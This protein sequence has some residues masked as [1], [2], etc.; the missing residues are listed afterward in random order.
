[1]GVDLGSVLKREEISLDH[2]TS[3][4]VAIDA[5]NTLYQFLSIIRQRDGTPL[6][7][8]EGRITSHLSGIIYRMSNLLERGVKP[9]FVFDGAPPMLKRK[10]LDKRKATREEALKKYGEAK[11]RGEEAFKYAQASARINSDIVEDSEELLG[12][13]GIP[14]VYAPSEG[15]AQAAFMVSKGDADFVASQDYDSMLFGA[16][17]LVR[18]LTISG[19]RKLPRKNVY[20]NVMPEEIRLEEVLEEL[21]IDRE[22]L[23]GVGILTGT[24]YNGGI[25][26]IGPKK[27]LKLI[28]KHGTIEK[29]LT[30]INERIEELDEVK[31]IFLNPNVTGDYEIRWGK[32]NEE[33]VIEFLCEEHGFSEMRVK[34]AL[35][36]VSVSTEKKRQKTLEG[37]F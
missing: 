4:M 16:K 36:K 26:G 25:K 11:E 7:D 28:K 34:K 33:K 8:S 6:M 5:Y 15:E 1:M 19:K 27:A 14:C 10:T 23:I 35:E 18:N 24:D 30:S 31:E 13:L 32:P 20:L 17:R 22:Q 37:W 21:G 29:V 2:L 12:Y 9:I 3:Y